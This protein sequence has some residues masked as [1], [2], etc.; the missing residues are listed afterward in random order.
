LVIGFH[1]RGGGH[2]G[3]PGTEFAHIAGG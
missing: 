1:V 2:D 3:L